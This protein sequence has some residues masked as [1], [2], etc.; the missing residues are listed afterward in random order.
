MIGAWLLESLI[1]MRPFRGRVRL[2]RLLLRW[3][4]GHFITSR[5]GVRMRIR[6]ADLT[7]QAAVAGTFSRDYDDVYAEVAALEPGMAFIDVGANHGLFTLVAGQRV[8]PDGAVLAFEPD[9]QSFH[10]LAG[11]VAE[12]Q[13]TSTFLF[14]AAV[15]RKNGIE[16]FQPG[17]PGHSGIGRIAPDGPSQ[18][19]VMNFTDNMPLLGTLLGGRRAV[20]KIDVEGHEA[21]VVS[22][23]SDLLKGPQVEKLIVEIDEKHLTRH[24]S[25][26]A[27]I[28]D[29]LA[30]AGFR[31]QRGPGAAPHYNDVFRRAGPSQFS[32]RRAARIAAR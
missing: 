4:D 22:A 19:M 27:E 24:G 23:L 12:N 30:V 8:G 3:A 17:P 15:S 7:N 13:L 26:A 32:Q 21:H 10:V 20:I 18:V 2:I 1:H 31:A 9:L 14:N 6:A 11:N 28:Y 25:T 16:A 5:Y 29:A